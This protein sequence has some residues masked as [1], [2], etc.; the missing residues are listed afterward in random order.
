MLLTDEVKM[1]KKIFIIFLLL[2]TLVNHCEAK[3]MKYIQMSL[4][5]TLYYVLLNNKEINIEQETAL[6]E[7]RGKLQRESGMFDTFFILKTQTDFEQEELSPLQI[8]DEK[9]KRSDIRNSIDSFKRNREK[10]LMVYSY[11]DCLSSCT[12]HFS[13]ND[14]CENCDTCKNCDDCNIMSFNTPGFAILTE[15]DKGDLVDA[16]DSFK[17]ANTF[18]LTWFNV[19]QLP[20]EKVEKEIL[21]QQFLSKNKDKITKEIGE[22]D[23]E[24]LKLSD[25]LAELGGVPKSDQSANL[26]MNV[27]LSKKFRN[28]IVVTPGVEMTHQSWQ[29]RHKKQTEPPLYK[30]K[31]NL[32]VLIPL[33]KNSGKVSAGAPEIKAI[34][35]YEAGL[36]NLR[37]VVSKNIYAS[38]IDYWDLVVTQDTVKI[39]NEYFSNN[40]VKR[41]IKG[42]LRAGYISKKDNNMMLAYTNEIESKKIQ[43]EN[44]KQEQIQKISQTIGFKST[45]SHFIVAT[46][47]FLKKKGFTFP[48]INRYDIASERK[49]IKKFESRVK[50]NIRKIINIALIRRE[51]YNAAKLLIESERAEMLRAKNDLK[52]KADL[53]LVM[54]YSGTE[55]DS[56]VWSGV[57]GVAIKDLTGPSFSATFDLEMPYQNNT[58]KGDLLVA[59]SN[60]NKKNLTAKNLL[61]TIHSRVNQSMFTLIN[62]YQQYLYSIQSEYHYSEVNKGMKKALENSEKTILDYTYNYNQLIDIRVNSLQARATYAKSLAKF[63]YETGLLINIQKDGYEIN[64]DYLKK[65]PDDIFFNKLINNEFINKP[66][67]LDRL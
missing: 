7:N 40:D 67:E 19:A 35:S 17:D 23:D 46:E 13:G 28:G 15:N 34:Y 39:Y 33:G 27:S 64:D 45:N 52:P 56:N 55:I 49:K 12:P 32:S 50:E 54:S 8:K 11:L 42:L 22:L 4:A 3:E 41:S 60:Y 47:T 65:I 14:S 5:Q 57:P 59:E 43:A 29:Y 38:I 62:A 48:K 44:K 16:Q 25:L 20:D 51:D 58:S 31:F 36:H 21:R 61:R 18:Y 1:F 53:Q 63:L 24:I 2:F 6:F 10:N 9:K 26:K 37:H 66:F 30:S